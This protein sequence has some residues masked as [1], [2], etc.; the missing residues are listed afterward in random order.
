MGAI[1]AFSYL[2]GAGTD[3]Y[4]PFLYFNFTL[5]VPLVLALFSP[6]VPPTCQGE[7][8]H[9]AQYT[10]MMLLHQPG[11]QVCSNLTLSCGLT[12]AGRCMQSH[13]GCL[14][15]H[16]LDYGDQGSLHFCNPHGTETIGGSF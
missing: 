12:T 13:R 16:H 10:P 15:G 14:G 11:R 1:F 3:G 9:Q 7:L 8:A 4:L 5:L 2:S 6:E